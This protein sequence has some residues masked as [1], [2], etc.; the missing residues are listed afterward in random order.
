MCT[1]ILGVDM[2]GPRSMILAANRD[3]DPE[4]P[5]D[6]PGVLGET[7][8]LVGGRD[9]R[10]GGTWLAVRGSEAAV[11]LLNRRPRGP[12]PAAPRSRGMLTMDV[13]AAP[14]GATAAEVRLREQ[15]AR[16][17]FGPFSLVWA[18]PAA[19]WIAT[20]DPGRPLE[21][22]AIGPGWHVVTHE[23]LDD[24]REPRTAWLAADLADWRPAGLE[25][26]VLGLRSRLA[27][28]AGDRPG[29]P[30]VC[31]HESRMVTVSS[32]LVWLD[33]SRARYLHAEGRP[34]VATWTDHTALLG[35][36][37]GDLP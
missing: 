25:E 1:L 15:V 22:G 35:T 34:C 4:R 33:G 17:P 20:H 31:I 9:R 18:S 19:C 36:R 8:R 16:H 10:A 26:A 11:A 23:S 29:A 2:L 30:E 13:A 37:T 14:A 27:L 28:H 7:P 21:V 12:G 3:E 6:P 5:A 32:S 24:A